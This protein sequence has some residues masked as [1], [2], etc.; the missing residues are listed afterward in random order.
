MRQR[1][2]L[3][4][5]GIHQMRHLPRGHDVTVFRARVSGA[6]ILLRVIAGEYGWKSRSAST[7]TTVPVDASKLSDYAG[8]YDTPQGVLEVR[9]G[10]GKLYVSAPSVSGGRWELLAIGEDRF[11]LAEEN[12]E[13]AFVRGAQPFRAPRLPLQ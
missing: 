3:D 13:I 1:L 10:G 7:R 5:A 2:G 8:R 12:E 11:L 4:P 9:T 6:P